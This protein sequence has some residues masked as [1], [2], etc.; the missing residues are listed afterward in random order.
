M[1]AFLAVFAGHQSKQ[2]ANEGIGC[3]CYYFS[4]PISLAFFLADFLNTS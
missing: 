3:R 4:Y 2:K 1:Q